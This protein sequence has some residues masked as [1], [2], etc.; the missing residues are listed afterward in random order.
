M[1]PLGSKCLVDIVPPTKFPFDRPKSDSPMLYVL[2]FESSLQAGASIL[3]MVHSAVLSLEHLTAEGSGGCAMVVAAQGRL[4]G[5]MQRKLRS[6]WLEIHWAKCHRWKSHTSKAGADGK[7]R[8]MERTRGPSLSSN[9]VQ[10]VW[11]ATSE[12]L[13]KIPPSEC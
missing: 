1:L 3:E 9:Q 4:Q 2:S 11:Q 13:K 10:S 8:V 5:Q 12:Y 7:A 6:I